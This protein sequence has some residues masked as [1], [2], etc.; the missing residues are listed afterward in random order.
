MAAPSTSSDAVTAAAG[1]GPRWAAVGRPS[2]PR[3]HRSSAPLAGL[4]ALI[5]I[6]LTTAAWAQ[7]PSVG[8]TVAASYAAWQAGEHA[9]ARDLARQAIALDDG[10]ASIVSRRVLVLALQELGEPAEALAELEQYLAFDLVP[11]DRQWADE[12]EVALRAALP[13]PDPEPV[14]VD[15]EPPVGDPEPPAVAPVEPDPV[16][17]TTSTG[18][19]P[20][21]FVLAAGG[22][23][24][25]LGP[26]SYGA[27]TAEVSVQLVS[28]LRLALGYQLGLVG[29]QPCSATEADGC[30]AALSSLSLG[31]QLRFDGAVSPLVTVAFLA[32]FNGGVDPTALSH[33]DPLMFGVEL[34]GGVD[35]GPGPVGVRVRGLF[36]LLSPPLDRGL[37]NP[38]ALISV[39]FVVRAGR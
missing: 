11:K 31:P 10:V 15:P 38:G 12:L 21:L 3:R 18:A 30:L 2:R 39:D 26:W 4:L 37:P 24:Q 5:L 16:P 33:Y 13:A 28:P 35:F 14:E 32:G 17:D 7:D 19:Q 6:S 29:D 1:A 36:R 20:P 8:E 25:Q 23:F 22:G 27:V 34:G 9:E